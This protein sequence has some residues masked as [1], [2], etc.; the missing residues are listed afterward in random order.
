MTTNKN[1]IYDALKAQFEAQKQKAL[2][3]LTIYL[4]NPVGIGEHPQHLEEMDKLVDKIAT[5]E[6]KLKSFNK[7]FNNTQI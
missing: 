5:A 3:T 4:T 6:D 7:H 2:A 1:I